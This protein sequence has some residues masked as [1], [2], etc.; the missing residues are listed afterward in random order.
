MCK[1]ALQVGKHTDMQKK[2]LAELN[3]II[4]S[5]VVTVKFA[6]SHQGVV[7]LDLL[8]GRL[9]GQGALEHCILV[10][11]LKANSAAG[12]R[13]SRQYHGVMQSI[14]LLMKHIVTRCGV[15]ALRA[16]PASQG[17]QRRSGVKQVN[18]GKQSQKQEHKVKAVQFCRMWSGVSRLTAAWESAAATIP[19]CRMMSFN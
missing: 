7:V 9:S 18:S 15:G 4:G 19:T 5:T 11:L 16:G 10:Q 1:Q 12:Q 14:R 13:D 2:H 17:Q 8:H 6:S 3:S